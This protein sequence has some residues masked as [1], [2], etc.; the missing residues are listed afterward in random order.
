MGLRDDLKVMAAYQSAG[1]LRQWFAG[2]AP[3]LDI[4]PSSIPW[5]D[6]P[7]PTAERKQQCKTK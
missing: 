7:P 3:C 5:E 6:V 4:N 1:Y 2:T